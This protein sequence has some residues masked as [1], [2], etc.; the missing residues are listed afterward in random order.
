[1]DINKNIFERMADVNFHVYIKT[2]VYAP[3]SF[4]DHRKEHRAQ[5]SEITEAPEKTLDC[6]KVLSS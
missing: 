4:Y 1:M 2:M 6:A 3:V 5:A